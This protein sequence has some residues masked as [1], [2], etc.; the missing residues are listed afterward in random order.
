MLCAEQGGPAADERPG[1]EPDGPAEPGRAHDRDGHTLGPG[2]LVP[3]WGKL[4][5]A[6]P[7]ASTLTVDNGET[8]YSCRRSLLVLSS[9]V[10]LQL[11]T[12]LLWLCISIVE[13]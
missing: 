4:N 12:P 13:Q 2:A 6:A 10:G 7:N 3:A 8:S 11:L 5:P 9:T 1:A